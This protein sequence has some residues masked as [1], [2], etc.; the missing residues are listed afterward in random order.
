MNA[1]CSEVVN[2]TDLREIKMSE[3]TIGGIRSDNRR[4]P[5]GMQTEKRIRNE[6]NDG[7]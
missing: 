6:K 1:A 5:F 4:G 3:I 7:D 2:C